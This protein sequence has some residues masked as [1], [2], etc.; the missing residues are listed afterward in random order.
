LILTLL[1]ALSAARGETNGGVNCAEL[2]FAE[3][4]MCSSCRRLKETVKD[5]NLVRECNAC[6]VDDS[7]TGSKAVFT[8]AVLEVCQ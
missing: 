2:G 1:A 7:D 6:C 3:T 4:L 8:S 5:E